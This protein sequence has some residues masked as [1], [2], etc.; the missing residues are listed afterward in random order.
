M[1]KLT[2]EVLREQVARA[3]AHTERVGHGRLLLAS[4]RR[5]REMDE[6]G[7]GEKGKSAFRPSLVDSLRPSSASQECSLPRLRSNPTGRRPTKLYE[8]GFDI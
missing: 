7:K 5:H 6:G 1:L 3:R 2:L 8:P 4:R